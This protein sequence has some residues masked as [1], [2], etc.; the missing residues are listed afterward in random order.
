MSYKKPDGLLLSKPVKRIE[1]KSAFLKKLEA[2][3]KGQLPKIAAQEEFLDKVLS[4]DR[5]RK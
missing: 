3:Q 2:F 4:F 1:P 5:G